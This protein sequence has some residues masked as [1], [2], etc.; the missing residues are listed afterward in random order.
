MHSHRASES[1]ASRTHILNLCAVLSL[2]EE[3]AEAQGGERAG[4]V[5]WPGSRHQGLDLLLPNL[6][7]C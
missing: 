5:T 4:L 3:G 2:K 6:V 7:P 1:C